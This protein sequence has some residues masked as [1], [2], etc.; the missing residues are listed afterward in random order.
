MLTILT[1]LN[2]KGLTTKF[3]CKHHFLELH[4]SLVQTQTFHVE[5][6]SP[7]HSLEQENLSSQKMLLADFVKSPSF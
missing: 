1:I 3:S 4:R 6:K 7:L 2:V 5:L